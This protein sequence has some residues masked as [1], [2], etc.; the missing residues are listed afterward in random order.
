MYSPFAA[1]FPYI[2]HLFVAHIISNTVHINVCMRYVAC[3]HKD[4]V[5]SHAVTSASLCADMVL[6]QHDDASST[7]VQHH[8]AKYLKMTL[9][10]HGGLARAVI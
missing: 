2:R 4:T 7:T 3:E 8:V 6:F 10:P 1:V 5:T 9:Y